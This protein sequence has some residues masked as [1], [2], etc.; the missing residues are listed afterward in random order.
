[1]QYLSTIIFI[2]TFFLNVFFSKVNADIIGYWKFDAGDGDIAYDSSSVGN[3]GVIHGPTWVEGIS[4]KALR[5]D[6]KKDYVLVGHDGSLTGMNVLTIDLWVKLAEEITGNSS[7]FVNIWG[8]GSWEDDAYGLGLHQMSPYLKAGVSGSSMSVDDKENVST[9]G[10]TAIGFWYHVAMVY[11][12]DSLKIY[13]NGTQAFSDESMGQPIKS[14]TKEL[15]MGHLS[16][17]SS[18]DFNGDIDEVRI[19]NVANTADEIVEYYESFLSQPNLISAVA[20]DNS[21]LQE[22]IDNDDYTLLTFDNAVRIFQVNS[23]NINTFFPLNNGHS[24]LSGFGSIGSAIWNP[25]STKLLVTLATAVSAPTI[26]IGDTIKFYKGDSV[27]VITGSFSGTGIITT[28][29]PSMGISSVWQNNY[30]TPIIISFNNTMQ[31]A[32]V[33]IFDIHGKNVASF[34]DIRDNTVVWNPQ[35]TPSGIYYIKLYSG[36]KTNLLKT[37]VVK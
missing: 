34:K 30:N 17:D 36:N 35:K 11:S 20:S 31:N 8:G 29:N 37:I 1:M 5:F 7:T 13:L 14:L 28:G 15:L 27:V 3:H 10:L 21:I 23:L 24:W 16:F 32:A 33:N 4:G 19:Q 25:E 18:S 2:A 26:S 6:G 22:G 9:I 12:G